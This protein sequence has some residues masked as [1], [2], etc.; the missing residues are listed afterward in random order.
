M[1]AYC[2]RVEEGA[3]CAW[4]SEISSAEGTTAERPRAS[5][6]TK[7]AGLHVHMLH[8]PRVHNHVCIA[9]PCDSSPFCTEKLHMWHLEVH[10]PL[11]HPRLPLLRS[12]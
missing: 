5:E 10:T 11:G 6:V 9:V 4:K 1:L 12:S 2:A 7:A 8:F 3:G